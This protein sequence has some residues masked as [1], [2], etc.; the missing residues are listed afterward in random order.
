MLCYE[1]VSG[2][3]GA[4]L[5][6][7]RVP[8]PDPLAEC[9]LCGMAVSPDG[10]IFVS[11]GLHIYKLGP[12]LK[13]DPVWRRGALSVPA[14][15]YP[16][17]LAFDARGRIYVAGT[18][19]PPLLA[20][21]H[22]TSAVCR[23]SAAGALE[24]CFD[25]GERLYHPRSIAVSGNALY[26][27]SSAKDTIIQ[28]DFHGNILQVWGGPGRDNGSFQNPL[29][30]AADTHGNLFIADNGNERIQQFSTALTK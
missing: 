21:S 20:P 12:D 18:S 19:V 7:W 30:I 4:E 15:R 27:S 3:T 1:L 24:Q 13:P 14:L 10:N 22:T 2:A 16:T 6:R 25:W 11:D 26:V 5:A 17:D 28:S 9:S 8:V 29:G 23:F